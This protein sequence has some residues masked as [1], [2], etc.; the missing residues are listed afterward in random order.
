MPTSAAEG[1]GWV[2][3]RIAAT[4]V[5]VIID[6]GPGEGT[7]SILARHLRLDAKW[8]GVEVHRPYIN[9][10]RLAEKYDDIWQMD[11][12]DVEW[13]V[14]ERFAAILGDVIEHLPR[15]DAVE[16]LGLLKAKASHLMVSVPIIESCQGEVDGNP[17]E[18]HLHQWSFGEMS[19]LLPGA[20]SWRGDI[21]GRWW[22]TN[23]DF[24]ESA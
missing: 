13:P 3:D 4:T 2:Y 9:R 24:K 19:T 1:R 20:E 7:Y 14:M 15:Q 8:I 10:Y 22:W 18:A 11:V 21:V 23:P 12:R 6:V 17:H 16:L 5:P